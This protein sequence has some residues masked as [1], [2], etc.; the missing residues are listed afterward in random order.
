MMKVLKNKIF[1]VLL[2][3]LGYAAVVCIVLSVAGIFFRYDIFSSDEKF[4]GDYET[5]TTIKNEIY[6]VLV[7][8]QEKARVY[9]IATNS[10]FANNELIIYEYDDILGSLEEHKSPKPVTLKAEE[11][12]PDK[13]IARELQYYTNPD[14]I[15]EV[16]YGYAEHVFSGFADQVAIKDSSYV[17]LT[18][19]QYLQIVY[20]N[21]EKFDASFDYAAADYDETDGLSDY[22]KKCKLYNDMW[23]HLSDSGIN[24]DSYFTMIDNYLY[25]YYNNDYQIYNEKYGTLYL[26]SGMSFSNN[27]YVPYS[28]KLKA[29][30]EMEN[31]DAERALGEYIL[32]NCLLRSDIEAI[33]TTLADSEK[34]SLKAHTY[35]YDPSSQGY[36]A[37]FSM[38]GKTIGDIWTNSYGV[39]T[40]GENDASKMS[41]PELLKV[42]EKEADI[43]I[44]YDSETGK[45]NQWYKNSK[46]EKA[47]YEYIDGDRLRRLI[48]DTNNDFVMSVSLDNARE[49]QFFDR[50][51][52]DLCRIVKNPVEILIIGVVVFIICLVLLI[53]GEKAVLYVVD[54]APYIVWF[55]IYEIII[56]AAAAG[57]NVVAYSLSVSRMLAEEYPSL[58]AAGL[59]VILILYLATFAVIM[60]V[61]RRIKCKKFLNGFITVILI[62]KLFGS[63][64]GMTKRLSGRVKLIIFA[65]MVLLIN[66]IAFFVLANAFCYGDFGGILLSIFMI[67]LD[68]FF[69]GIFLRNKT[70]MNIILETSRRIENGELSAKVDVTNLSFDSREMGESL[71][72]LGDGLSKAVEASLRDERT[73]AELITNVSHDIKTPL[74]SIINYVDLL[75]KEDIDNEKAREYIDVLDKKSERLKQL[76]LDLIEVSKTSTGNIDLECTR[77][78]FKEL[79]TQCIGE[80]EEKLQE[81]ELELI[82]DLAEEDISIYADGR[83]VFRIID[84]LLNNVTKYAQPQSRVYLD[85]KPVDDNKVCLSIKNISEKMLNISAQELAERFVRGDR[86]RNTEGS[87][88]GLSIAKNLTELQGGEFTITVDGDLFKVEVIFPIYM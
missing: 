58:I 7:N 67:I 25:V 51:S 29:I 21:C 5:S 81:K 16:S 40:Y 57:M 68:A 83:R 55:L 11:I 36:Y 70:D 3:V 72:R 82:A 64:K 56:I 77:L 78:N 52:Y 10:D 26:D 48:S 74:T 32:S 69:I 14:Y 86:S 87:G 88:L 15:E 60:N 47:D 27:V 49:A 53:C 20:D 8:E 33:Y 54:K 18:W 35:G 61:V 37:A 17:R 6:S 28:N 41:Y 19:E 73:K 39:F 9:D 79:I 44:S 4:E 2:Y 63:F 59:L 24:E 75:K 30:L 43:F 76:I 22:D 71:N 45:L 62:R 84:N 42:Y 23:K 34:S 12:L 66:S 80:Y 13:D 1:R 38:D 85:L 65:A 31:E 50:V 46:G